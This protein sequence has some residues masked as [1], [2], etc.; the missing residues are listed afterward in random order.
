MKLEGLA[1]RRL[2]FALCGSLLRVGADISSN[3]CPGGEITDV[4]RLKGST[5]LSIF[6]KGL[7]GRGVKEAV[8]V[9]ERR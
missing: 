6:V 1:L 7:V 4:T 8:S 3:K 5:L 2:F 9:S